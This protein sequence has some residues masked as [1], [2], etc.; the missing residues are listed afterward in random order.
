LDFLQVARIIKPHGL[1]GE[2]GVLMHW[3][4]SE[5][6]LVV[7]RVR[8]ELADGTVVE[9]DVAQV[10]K[11]GRGYRIKFV[12]VDDCNAAEALRG[13]TL[14]VARAEL[15]EVGPGEAFLSDLVG[16]QVLGPDAAVV[17][18]VVETISY[19]SVDV[20]VIERADGSRVEQPLVD[21][22]VEPLDGTAK[23]VVLRS[24]DGLVG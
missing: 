15:P 4:E 20:L 22:W 9:R 17:G 11:H 3:T 23:C 2:V 12:G 1:G 8:L 13:A 6:L 16:R 14:S 5:A 21:D 24:L 18:A 7:K 19:P 10:H